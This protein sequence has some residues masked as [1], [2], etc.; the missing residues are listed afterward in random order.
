MASDRMAACVVS[1]SPGVRGLASRKGSRGAPNVARYAIVVLVCLVF[2]LF[3]PGRGG[4]AL[5]A[6]LFLVWSLWLVNRERKAALLA[7]NP[8]VCYQVWQAGTL[9]AAALY[10]PLSSGSGEGVPLLNYRLSLEEIAYAHAVMLVGSWALYAGMKRFQ[11]M[12]AGIGAKGKWGT[13]GVS[14]LIATLI[15]VVF[16]VGKEVLTTYT[17][18]TLLQL[19]FLPLAVLCMVAL[20]PPR[21]LRISAIAQFGVLLLGSACVLLL[22]GRRDS[23]M[24]LIFSFL[25]VLWWALS[26][27]NRTT[28]AIVGLGLVAFYLAVIVPLVT[29]MRST[30]SRDD[31]G[32]VRTL[33]SGV[34]ERGID[35]MKE[36]FSSAPG[37][38]LGTWLDATMDRMCDPCVVAL[39][40]RLARSDGFLWGRG[41]DYVPL[42]FVPRALWRDKAPMDRGRY[43]TTALGWASDPSLATTS[44]G[45]TSAGE[46]YWNFGWPGVLIGMYI[47]GAALSGLWWRAAGGDPR[48]GV[49]EMAAY[50]SAMLSFVLGTGSAAGGMFAGAITAGLF[51]RAAIALRDK[52]FTRK[53]RKSKGSR[54]ALWVSHAC[55]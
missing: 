24:D 11:P 28:V 16:H 25:P 34:T 18:S 20:N 30:G 9:G 40:V 31:S 29:F 1:T 22:N 42:S 4:L 21:L 50:V 2:D 3:V 15:G 14:L 51:W 10:L 19:G 27:G 36:N 35:T 17:G 8:I 53:V 37:E 13:P 23:K 49:L 39:V 26:R 41:L 6:A 44:T 46:L 54:T 45:Q 38:Y 48:R 43:F 32:M 47:L 5:S 12:E 55:E 52:G 7:L 33:N